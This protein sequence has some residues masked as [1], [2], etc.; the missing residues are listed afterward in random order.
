MRRPAANSPSSNAELHLLIR[1]V[2]KQRIAVTGLHIRKTLSE[3]FHFVSRDYSLFPVHCFNCSGKGF[4][5]PSFPPVKGTSLST[6]T[7]SAHLTEGAGI[8]PIR[9]FRSVM[10]YL[11]L[12]PTTA[13]YFGAA[14][15]TSPGGR[16]LKTKVETF[17]PGLKGPGT[18][19]LTG[20]TL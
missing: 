14:A 19:W 8:L 16:I 9:I 17:S 6:C 10:V 1:C 2:W 3:N 13:I 12:A 11:S 20:F 15:A 7:A 4:P 18:W 5:I